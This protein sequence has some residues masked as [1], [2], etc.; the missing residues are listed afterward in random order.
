MESRTSLLVANVLLGKAEDFN[1]FQKSYQELNMLLIKASKRDREKFIEMLKNLALENNIKDSYLKGYSSFIGDLN[2]RKKTN[3]PEVEYHRSI[4]SELITFNPLTNPWQLFYEDRLQANEKLDPDQL[5]VMDQASGAAQL[6]ALIE[7][8]YLLGMHH[9]FNPSLW[10]TKKEDNIGRLDLAGEDSAKKAVML[11]RGLEKYQL[12]RNRILGRVMNCLRVK[13]WE[14]KIQQIEKQTQEDIKKIQALKLKCIVESNA[15]HILKAA[16][17]K[18]TG[19]ETDG[20]SS[21]IPST[22]IDV[23]TNQ[24]TQH[25]SKSMHDIQ[26]QCAIEGQESQQLDSKLFW[27]SKLEMAAFFIEFALVVGLYT[28]SKLRY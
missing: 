10:Y 24:E 6:F 1:T 28:I 5:K 15:S 7:K 11:C 20:L 22:R 12:C 16:F 19:Q 18:L 25:Q 23:H 4:K 3:P 9:F 26:T 8:H 17:N 27:P 21:E 2:Q 13:V 14:T